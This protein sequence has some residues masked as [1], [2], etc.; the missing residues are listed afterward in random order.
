[1]MVTTSFL[2]KLIEMLYLDNTWWWWWWQLW[3]WKVRRLWLSDSWDSFLH[4]RWESW[5]SSPSRLGYGRVLEETKGRDKG[6]LVNIIH[7]IWMCL[8]EDKGMKQS[9]EAKVNELI[10]C[11]EYGCVLQET[12][13]KGKGE[14]VDI[15]PRIWTCPGRDKGKRQKKE[16]NVNKLILCLRY[17]HI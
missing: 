5:T 1:M 2:H 6:E 3:P 7:L 17:G 14:W 15:M 16:T 11:L 4:G 10:L 13:W 12:K 9:E 8:E